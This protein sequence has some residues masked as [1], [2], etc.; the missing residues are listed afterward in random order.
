[1]LVYDIVDL[2]SSKQRGGLFTLLMSCTDDLVTDIA[3][4]AVDA[5]AVYRILRVVGRVEVLSFLFERTMIGH[6]S[7]T[8][9]SC[10]V[11]RTIET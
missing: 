4:V 3:L 8:D 2:V 5:S 9:L 1:M 7:C 6:T 10:T 11:S